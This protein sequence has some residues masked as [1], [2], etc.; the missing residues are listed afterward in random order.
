MPLKNLW[1]QSFEDLRF[2]SIELVKSIKNAINL[3]IESSNQDKAKELNQT[4]NELL[5]GKSN[6]GFLC[7]SFDENHPLNKIS[8]SLI[9]SPF[10]VIKN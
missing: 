7:V 9:D 10:D 6:Y 1:T 2:G 5:F 8:K 3:Y 4:L